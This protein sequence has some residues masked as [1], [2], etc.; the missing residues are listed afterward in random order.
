MTTEVDAEKL[1]GNFVVEH[2][3]VSMKPEDTMIAAI[4]RFLV[5]RQNQQYT[6]AHF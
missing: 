3:R 5:T 6:T 2:G 1:H 4:R